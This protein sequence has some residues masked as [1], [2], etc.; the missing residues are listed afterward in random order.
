MWTEACWK[1]LKWDYFM[2][3]TLQVQTTDTSQERSTFHNAEIKNQSIIFEVKGLNVA[4]K[5]R[6]STC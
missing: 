6:N 2:H 3:D 5:A 4:K 1:T